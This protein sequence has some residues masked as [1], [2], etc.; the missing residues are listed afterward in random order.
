MK[1][2]ISIIAVLLFAGLAGCGE[3]EQEGTSGPICESM[4]APEEMESCVLVL[5]GG[6]D[7]AVE[8]ED[9][10]ILCENRCDTITDFRVSNDI[11]TLDPLKNIREV[12]ADI[13]AES[14][15]EMRDLSGT[16]NIEAT[17]TVYPNGWF[18]IDR[19]YSLETTDGFDAVREISAEFFSVSANLEL[20]QLAGFESLE[21]INGA[22]VVRDNRKLRRITG[23]ESLDYIDGDL[24]FQDNPQLP[25]CEIERFVEGIDTITGEVVIE[26]NGT[27]DCN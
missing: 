18:V 1:R 26:G 25:R 15:F 21:R 5:D 9:M 17:G 20:R 7:S 11:H 23:F 19:N 8:P 10:Q 12:Q 6:E 14:T 3:S 2:Q 16:E 4:P 13:R 22:V 27:G 24:V